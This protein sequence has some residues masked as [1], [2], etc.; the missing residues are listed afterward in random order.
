MHIKTSEQLDNVVPVLPGTVAQKW[1]VSQGCVTCQLDK[2]GRS[3][4]YDT[5]CK[6]LERFSKHNWTCT[7]QRYPVMGTGSVTVICL[8]IFFSLWM[9]QFRNRNGLHWTLL[10]LFKEPYDS[11]SADEYGLFYNTFREEARHAGNMSQSRSTVKVTLWPNT[12]RC[13][14]SQIQNNGSF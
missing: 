9:D 11:F 3:G 1:V 8:M 5:K 6:L 13:N 7:N 10:H 12:E 2:K 4:K 14:T